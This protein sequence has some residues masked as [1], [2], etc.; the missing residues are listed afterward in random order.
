MTG[1]PDKLHEQVE[2]FNVPQLRHHF[3]FTFDLKRLPPVVLWRKEASSFLVRKGQ[4]VLQNNPTVNWKENLR[5]SFSVV[6]PSVFVRLWFC[7]YS[8]HYDFQIQRVAFRTDLKEVYYIIITVLEMKQNA[9][10]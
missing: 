8:D 2:C 7:F 1:L 5:N 4:F 6:L 9:F 3:G 10:L